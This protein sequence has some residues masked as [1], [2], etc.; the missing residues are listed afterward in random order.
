MF[1][2][3]FKDGENDAV[4]LAVAFLV[5]GALRFAIGKTLPDAEGGEEEEQLKSHTWWQVLCLFGAALFFA[6]LL[7]VP[8]LLHKKK[9]EKGEEGEGEGE[10]EGAYE[11]YLSDSDSEE[12]DEEEEENLCEAVWINLIDGGRFKE[13]L[14]TT[15][16]LVFV[17]AVYYTTTWTI[18]L[19]GVL[20]VLNLTGSA[21]DESLM[22]ILIAIFSSLVGF[23]SMV[24]LD[25]LADSN[26]TD[27]V[28]DRAIRK[29]ISAVGVLIGFAWEQSF[30]TE[31][32]SVTEVIDLGICG[33][34]AVVAAI[35][36]V[37]VPAWVQYILPM[38]MEHGYRFGIIPR[39]IADRA[40]YGF[41]A[42]D[43]YKGDVKRLIGWASTI[44]MLA[45]VI[46]SQTEKEA[47]EKMLKEAA[48]DT[49]EQGATDKE[50]SAGEECLGLRR[51]H[52]ADLIE[53]LRD[54]LE[55]ET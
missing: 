47:E 38:Q 36:L 17:L 2:P 40:R 1:A 42:E 46:P 48:A 18:V 26:F 7:V 34:L 41:E 35:I 33:E 55:P 30:D 32:E 28:A 29:L 19:S 11:K 27:P 49:A 5:V 31:M 6:L 24:M 15:F 25:N 21:L 13:V 20:D 9:E 37:I 54:R 12:E 4:G 50:E 14:M 44:A 23:V 51:R 16:S 39:K 52:I 45:E 3:A 22:K 53:T 43:E 8:V 10:E